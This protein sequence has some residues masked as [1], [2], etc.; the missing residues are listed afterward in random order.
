MTF[1]KMI[2]LIDRIIIIITI[3][4]SKARYSGDMDPY[5]QRE[6]GDRWAFH[7]LLSGSE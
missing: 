5:E 3:G 6:Q 7:L 2:L 4:S 1:G